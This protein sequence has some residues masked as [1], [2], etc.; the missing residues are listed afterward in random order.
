M[1]SDP[2]GHPEVPSVPHGGP[3]PALRRYVIAW[4][5]VG[6]VAGVVL[7][8]TV[9]PVWPPTAPGVSWLL[10]PVLA[11]TALVLDSSAVRFRGGE[12]ASEAHTLDELV[13]VASLLLL[14][15]PWP[16]IVIVGAAVLARLRQRTDPLRLWFNVGSYATA[17]AAALLV[18]ASV[19]WGDPFGPL[20]LLAVALSLTAFAVI[21]WV[22]M[23]G[24]KVH[25][26]V[27]RQ[28][29]AALLDGRLHVAV[30]AAVALGGLGVVAAFL[31]SSRPHLAPLLVVPLLAVRQRSSAGQAEEQ[32]RRADHR[33]LERTVAGASDGI[34]L[35]DGDGRVAVWN[36][37]MARLTGIPA[38]KALGEAADDVLVLAPLTDPPV[39][40]E[41]THELC[42]ATGRYRLVA[43]HRSEVD[44]AAG[45]LGTVLLVRD[46]TAEAEVVMLREDLISRVSHELRTPLTAITGLLQTVT[47]RWSQLDDETRL[48]LLLPALSAG[49]RMNRLIEGLLARGRIDRG[50]GQPDRV[51]ARLDDVVDDLVAELRVSL[52]LEVRRQRAP[53]DAVVD[54]DHLAQILVALLEN[55]ARYGRGPIEITTSASGG[56]ARLEVRDHGDGIPEAFHGQLFEPFSQASTGLRRTARGLGLGL[57]IARELAEA[58]GGRLVHVSPPGGGA[59]FELQLP[60][61]AR[62]P[63]PAGPPRRSS[64]DPARDDRGRSGQDFT[65]VRPT[66]GA[67]G[68]PPDVPDGES[69]T[70][71]GSPWPASS[72]RSRP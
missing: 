29:R 63:D 59:S 51:V 32:A 54:V 68:V 46:V 49:Q 64:P 66:R 65:T 27:C 43:V 8:L 47:V 71:E 31:L 5:V 4:A 38:G 35:V 3:A 33:R 11:A 58:N 25:V 7:L 23:A 62:D 52:D 24:I 72:G 20:G 37:A 40:S 6:V 28:R 36:E 26:G 56:D 57:S 39:G 2:P 34:V 22:A 53:V 55:A 50:L 1:T 19:P 17:T 48:E 21:N 44:L 69:G 60:L 45:D 10:L 12:D 42:P 30:P 61:G 18:H 67:V 13:L 15:P 41:A 70:R 9:P 16:W 14:A